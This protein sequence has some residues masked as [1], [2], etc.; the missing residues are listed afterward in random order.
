MR[1]TLARWRVLAALRKWRLQASPPIPTLTPPIQD[2][3]FYPAAASPPPPP[4]TPPTSALPPSPDAFRVLQL[5]QLQPPPELEDAL[6]QASFQPSASNLASLLDLLLPNPLFAL[7]AFLWSLR[8]PSFSASS[9]LL[10]P[11]LSSLLPTPRPASLDRFLAD[12]NSFWRHPDLPL[13]PDLLDPLVSLYCHASA[14]IDEVIEVLNLVLSKGGDPR[15]VHFNQVLYAAVKKQKLDTAQWLFRRMQSIGRTPDIVSFNILINGCCDLGNLQE[16]FDL[17]REM[18]AGGIV[19]TATT[20]NGLISGV[21]KVGQLDT[22]MQLFREMKYNGHR[23]SEETYAGITKGFCQKGDHQ[24]ARALLDEMRSEGI[25]LD[26][27]TFEALVFTLCNAAGLHEAE[28]RR[29]LDGE[30][31]NYGAWNSGT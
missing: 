30:P 17:F 3:Y 29:L 20:Y 8:H 4:E 24:S 7:R 28:A 10:S 16:A 26:E 5:L 21:T 6:S 18:T 31:L 19:P 25:S 9:P 12:L 27:K 23:R 14:S 22:A 15:V 2:D 13:P 11:R 1:T